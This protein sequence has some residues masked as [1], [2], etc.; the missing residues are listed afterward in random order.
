MVVDGE[1]DKTHKE[2]G[3]QKHP[4]PA[5]DMCAKM[6]IFFSEGF[7]NRPHFYGMKTIKSSLMKILMVGSVMPDFRPPRYP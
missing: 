4:Y 1:G 7:H 5:S 6:H 3:N 2:A